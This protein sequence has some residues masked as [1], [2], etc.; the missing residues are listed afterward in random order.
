PVHLTRGETYC[1]EKGE[2]LTA[3]AARVLEQNEL[4]GPPEACALFFQPGLEALAHSGW[5]I[6]L[7][8][9][10]ACW[11]DIGEMEGLTVLSLAAIYAAHY[12]QPCG[13]LARDP[14][15]TLAIGIVKP[16]G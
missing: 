15:N 3:V 9:Q 2:A 7:Y 12:Q 14:L 10:D 16:D 13:W 5:D 8:R 6:N 11:G 1:A 4:S